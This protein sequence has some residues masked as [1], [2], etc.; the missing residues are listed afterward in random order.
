MSKFYYLQYNDY[1]KP[2]RYNT[3]ADAKQAYGE[4]VEDTKN[5]GNTP[6]AATVHI[7]TSRSAIAEYPDYVLSVG[8]RGGIRLEK[9]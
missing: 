5:L 9:A 7:A 3:L 1:S 6:L 2:E 8:P 4:Y